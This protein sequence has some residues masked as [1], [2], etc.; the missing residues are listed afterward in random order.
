MRELMLSTK[1]IAFELGISI[2]SFYRLVD[3]KRIRPYQIIKGV[4][5]YHKRQFVKEIIKY[6]PIKTIE[7]FYIYESK[8]NKL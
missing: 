8:I 7:T 5:F 2:S 4:N 3:K 6:Y 1:E